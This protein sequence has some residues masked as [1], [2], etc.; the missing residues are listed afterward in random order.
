MTRLNPFG[1]AICWEITLTLVHVS[2]V[3]LVVALLAAMGD[4]VLRGAPAWTRYWSNF[5]ALIVLGL[6]LPA[7]WLAVHTPSASLSDVSS[8]RLSPPRAFVAPTLPTLSRDGGKSLV[9][10]NG[11][12]GRSAAV[13]P[14]ENTRRRVASPLELGR[15]VRAVSPFVAAL[16][17][18]GVIAMLAKLLV[19]LQGGQRLRTA[20]T[21]VTEAEIIGIL[22]RQAQRLGV[23]AVPLLC[24]CERVAVPVVFGALQPMILLPMAMATGLSL[25][26][27]SAILSHELAHIRRRD[28]WMILAQRLVEAALFFHPVAWRLSR[29]ADEERENCCDDLVLSAGADRLIYAGAL[30]R[31]AE[32]R[33]AMRE[34]AVSPAA[35]GH[36]PSGL[37]RRIT[38]LLRTESES[39][40]RVSRASVL[41]VALLMLTIGAVS[42]T[43]LSNR[44]E[45]KAPGSRSMVQ[46]QQDAKSTVDVRSAWRVVDAE[47]GNPLEG[48]A[49]KVDIRKYQDVGESPEL[50]DSRMY[51]SDSDGRFTVILPDHLRK[52]QL[53][54]V[55][56]WGSL[57][58]R[59]SH[60]SRL[61]YRFVRNELT[62]KLG[63]LRLPRG[64]TVFGRI[65]NPDRS[66]ASN[67]RLRIDTD[68]REALNLFTPA[69]A[70]TDGDGKFRLLIP[71]AG[72]AR[73]WVNSSRAV[74]FSRDLGD[75]R[76]DLGDIS[77]SGGKSIRGRVLDA[78]GKPVP[79]ISVGVGEYYDDRHLSVHGGPRRTITDPEGRFELP[80]MP[81][82]DYQ[83]APLAG[84]D[85][86]VGE[87]RADQIPE[88][89]RNAFAKQ[90][91]FHW[92]QAL[93]AAFPRTRVHLE[94][95]AA[96]PEIELKAV[97][98]V[99]FTARFVDGQGRLV[100]AGTGMPYDLRGKLN[101]E[102]WETQL[103]PLP[104]APD[105]IRAAVPIGLR[106][107]VV[108]L[109]GDL[110]WWTSTPDSMPAT[111]FGIRLKIVEHD[112]PEILVQRKRSASLEI[113]LRN[114]AG[115]LPKEP[116]VSLVYPRRTGGDGGPILTPVSPGIYRNDDA[117]LPDRDTEV[118]VSAPGFKSIYTSEFHFTEEGQKGVIEIQLTPGVSN[119]DFVEVPAELKTPGGRPIGNLA[120]PAGPEL[121]IG[122]RATDRATG[123]A[124]QGA[125]VTIALR[126]WKD[127]DGEDRQ[128][129][130]IEEHTATTDAQGRFSVTIPKKYVPPRYPK[131]NLGLMVTIE[132]P[133]YVAFFDEA[134]TRKIAEDGVSETF[135]EFQNVKLLPAREVVGRVLGPDGQPCREVGI[136]KYYDL[137]SGIFDAD[138]NIK[139]DA[140]GRF[141]IKV[142]VKTAL[143][144]EFRTSDVADQKF[145]V[146]EDQTD[147]G[148][149]RLAR[150]VR[151][152]GRVF[153]PLGKPVRRISLT[154]PRVDSKD[155]LNTSYT[156]DKDGRFRSEQLLPGKYLVTVGDFFETEDG[157]RSPIATRKAPGI[158]PPVPIEIK[159]GEP[160]AELHLTAVEP[161]HCET[162]LISTR[163]KGTRPQVKKQGDKLDSLREF[164]AL[165]AEGFPLFNVEGTYR[166]T[167]WKGSGGSFLAFKDDGYVVPVPRGLDNATLVFGPV[168]QHIQVD[169]N[170]PKIFGHSIRVGRLDGDLNQI[171][172]YRYRNTTL[173][174]R[175]APVG[176]KRGLPKIQA[177]YVREPAMI[178]AGA[179][180]KVDEPLPRSERKADGIEYDVL[181]G[182]EIELWV[183]GGQVVR[184]TLSEGETREIKLDPPRSK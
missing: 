68:C 145:D 6:T 125:K 27:L 181:P 24:Y 150:G 133:R 104:D 155:P 161:I 117:L 10:E 141:R 77:L 182:E 90:I 39:D 128:L 37:R 180:F 1:V 34:V 56:L 92:S 183:A 74:P 174:V 152:V 55:T 58:G 44:A 75:T 89:L 57:E 134:F 131:Q 52:Y 109:H 99:T 108:D 2:W 33:R 166:G 101:G 147:L 11:S 139:T 76:G 106:D 121:T 129:R 98:H 103:I 86:V 110:V 19:A 7:V 72:K 43:F 151:V 42:L 21:P 69:T 29:R 81:P 48:A 84:L 105:I 115:E 170:S 132:H 113:R 138:V 122:C 127:P 15:V 25:D 168:T 83:V 61:D 175:V 116:V 36:R 59:A 173:H 179:I 79:H 65:L 63:T 157:E 30:V 67:Q 176:D 119:E 140:E 60:Y 107:A 87:T 31:V 16:Y 47:T 32:L 171:Q 18:L 159:D 184:V 17:G 22:E 12:S 20:S 114:P 137:M 41:A 123:E 9:V 172:V 13:I 23:H 135:P 3:G 5:A 62:T 165:M 54:E 136:Y 158:F 118:W 112:Q 94:P 38:R 93:P 126:E 71:A 49:I 120:E 46:E 160:M 143:K 53:I 73:L 8:G 178:A 45:S 130:T 70:W 88:S 51:R 111:G 40:V 153:D 148:D 164:A 167:V 35:D 66:P 146:L 156:T 149:I 80:A 163:A 28:H 85:V 4:R 100:H 102:P 154:I 64:E 78:S 26:Q 91:D 177:R 14:K 96:A 97:S 95:G 144:L 50:L 124:V 82:G 142:P 162:T 169:R